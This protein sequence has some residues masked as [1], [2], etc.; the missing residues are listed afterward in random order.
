MIQLFN[1]YSCAQCGK[2]YHS[3]DAPKNK[4]AISKKNKIKKIKVKVCCNRSLRKI[5]KSD[6]ERLK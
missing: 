5:T 6:Y 3:L 2:V 1:Y 4:T